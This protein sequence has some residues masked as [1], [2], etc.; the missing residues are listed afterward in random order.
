M[1]FLH[2]FAE[3]PDNRSIIPAK[4]RFHF[5]PMTHF[6]KIL[7]LCLFCTLV[8]GVEPTIV[9]AG[10]CHTVL[11]LDDLGS[12]VFL[13]Q[14]KENKV[15]YLTIIATLSE[16]NYGMNFNGYAKGEAGYQ[17]P[18][19]WKV[20]VTFCN[21]SPVP[22]SVIVVEADDAKRKI[23]LGNEPYFEGAST[24]EPLRG[25]TSKVETFEFTVDEVGNFAL[26]CG[27]P[28]HSVNGHWIRLEVNSDFQNASFVRPVSVE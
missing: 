2:R 18:I 22:H 23:N 17:I 26:A 4:I 9:P 20:I 16:H 13:T 25:T 21:N 5:R 28:T 3:A 27:F 24:P 7:L 6:F 10:S 12:P 8:Q 11:P 1:I 15:A 19:G 14:D